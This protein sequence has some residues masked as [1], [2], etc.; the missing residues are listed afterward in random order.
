MSGRTALIGG[1]P[2]VILILYIPVLFI[3]YII[4]AY[5]TGLPN[6]GS[7]RVLHNMSDIATCRINLRATVDAK[8][9]I[10]QAADAMGTTLSAFVLQSAYE[11]AARVLHEHQLLILSARDREAFLAALAQPPAPTEAL[12]QLLRP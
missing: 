9:L 12:R 1:V 4:L 6:P 3:L 5:N 11:A 2:V 7:S 8:Q 10:E